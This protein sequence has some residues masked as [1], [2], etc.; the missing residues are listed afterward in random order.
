[1]PY[2]RPAT[3]IAPLI[4]LAVL[5]ARSV[6]ADELAELEQH[7]LHAAVERVADSV[8]QI[9]TVGGLDRIDDRQLD[10]G[11]TTGLIVA[12]DG[13][14]V[15]SAYGFAQQPASILVLLPGGEQRPARLVGRD[16]NRMLVLLKVDADEPL[17][18]PEA[19]PL[20]EVRPGDWAVAVGRTYSADEVSMS[21]GVVSALGRMHGRALQTD[22]NVSAANYGG[23]LVDVHGRVLGVLAPM[24]PQTGADQPSALAGAEFYDSGI[25]FAVPLAH[26]NAVLDRWQRQGDLHRG[27]LGVSLKPGNPHATPPIIT[28]VWPRSPAAAAGWRAGDRII[29]VDDAPIRSQTELRLKLTP[30]YAGDT[31]E[32]TVRRGKSAAAVTLVA[33][34]TLAEKL[35]AYRHA[36][37]GVLPARADD[38]TTTGAEAGDESEKNDGADAQQNDSGVAVR[39]VWPDS[40][41]DRAG[42]RPGDRVTRL[43]KENAA[44]IAA[45]ITA[46]NAHSAGDSLA[47]EVQRAGEQLQLDVELAELPRDILASSDFPDEDAPADPAPAQL[48]LEE[49]KLPESKQTARFVQPPPAG[50]PPGLVV[51]LG[52]GTEEAARALAES[53]QR[54]L[55][56]HRFMLL[57]P[58]P[59]DAARGWT[60][61]DMEH[62]VRLLQ[63]AV[64]RFSVDPRRVVIVGEAKAGQLAYALA[65]ESRQAVRGVVTLDSPLPRTLALPDNNPNVRLAILSIET[66]DTPLAPLLRQDRDKLAAAGYPVTLLDRA[67]ETALPGALDAATRAKIARWIDALDRF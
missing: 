6:P 5:V 45:A 57:M 7:A 19:A 36:F 25:G 62:L 24:S 26:V 2:P 67:G 35:P 44:S 47:V 33:D 51:W 61:D 22:A 32:A 39:A 1:M 59:G 21:V 29:A 55:R 12:A 38:Q 60:S 64:S 9:R 15:A 13:H 30:R 28:A 3:L 4:A 8:V 43:G 17:P 66:P 42:M 23:P 41:A 34:V 40:P 37:L 56:R 10:Q 65:F 20:A 18:V 16:H 27:L 50:P 48:E 46:M 52:D 14:I 63:T 11:P 54:S 31:F 49:L 58:E 53:W